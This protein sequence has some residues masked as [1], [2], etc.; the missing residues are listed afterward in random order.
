MRFALL[1]VALCLVGCAKKEPG[2]QAEAT[3]T[4]GAA[5][6]NGGVCGPETTAATPAQTSCGESSGHGCND[7]CGCDKD[8][9]DKKDSPVLPVAEAKPGDRTR[10]LVTNTVFRVQNDSP[11]VDHDGKTYWFCC[12]GC[13]EKFKSAPARFLGS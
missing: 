7:S 2:A 13:A 5:L 8:K 1:A 4:G 3:S 11:S 6:A 9:A 12:E 10:C